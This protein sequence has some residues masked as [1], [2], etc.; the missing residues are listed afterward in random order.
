MDILKTCIHNITARPAACLQLACAL[1]TAAQGAL[2]ILELAIL[3]VRFKKSE[4]SFILTY[5]R[6]IYIGC[7]PNLQHACSVHRV[8]KVH[9]LDGVGPVD[10]RPSTD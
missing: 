1:P 7:L 9:K 2:K 5:F 4:L 8:L 6:H 10:N 3:F